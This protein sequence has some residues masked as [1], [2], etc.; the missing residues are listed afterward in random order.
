MSLDSATSNAMRLIGPLF[1]GLLYQWLGLGGAFGLA[2]ALYA[3]CL[4][5]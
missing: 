2:A 1:G 3:L 5:R 4:M